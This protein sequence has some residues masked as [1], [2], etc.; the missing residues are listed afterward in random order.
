MFY[1][2]LP[3]SQAA[4]VRDAV[5]CLFL[6]LLVWAR[7]GIVLSCPLKLG[8][9]MELDLVTDLCAEVRHASSW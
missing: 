1:P 7:G 6:V 2:H 5:R 9:V 3:C 4:V 8:M